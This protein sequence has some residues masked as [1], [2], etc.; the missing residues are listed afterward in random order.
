MTKNMKLTK[1]DQKLANQI[2]K[3]NKSWRRWKYA[4]LII[5]PILLIAW[6][7][8]YFYLTEQYQSN[9][10][11]YQFIYF[12]FLPL[13]VINCV[14]CGIMIGKVIRDW[15]GN[16]VDILLLRIIKNESHIT[17]ES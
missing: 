7:A 5:S 9:P 15:N 8:M 13:M 6:F 17:D 10:D 3:R 2:I 1:T 16:A 14:A 12:S 4:L 11:L